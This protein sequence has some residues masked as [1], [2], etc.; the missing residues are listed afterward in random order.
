MPGHV[1]YPWERYLA[2]IS[3]V[4]PAVFKM[5]TRLKTVERSCQCVECCSPYGFEC[6]PM[7]PRELRWC[8]NEQVC[9]G[10]NDVKRTEHFVGGA[11]PNG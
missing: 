9:W 8:W 4:H 1:V 10:N 2:P 5:G 11:W 7:L 3:S 6:I